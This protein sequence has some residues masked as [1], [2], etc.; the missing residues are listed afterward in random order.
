MSVVLEKGNL[1][2][3][4]IEERYFKLPAN[5]KFTLFSSVRDV[6]LEEP[7]KLPKIHIEITMEDGS[8][9]ER[10]ATVP[11]TWLQFATDAQAR[12]QRSKI[13]T[14]SFLDNLTISSSH[15]RTLSLVLP[16]WTSRY[17]HH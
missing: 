16:N 4:H 13:V 17:S 5:S 9:V 3:Q 14:K 2:C 1:E 7:F 11:Y 10:H 8:I 15:L 12:L 6:N